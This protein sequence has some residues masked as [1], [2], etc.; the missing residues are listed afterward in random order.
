MSRTPT[1]VAK[2][3]IA[4]ARVSSAR[5][6]EEGWSLDY[7]EERLRD[8]AQRSGGEI[9]KLY[10]VTETASKHA[11]RETFREMLAFARANA[12]RLD[13]LLVMKIDRAARNMRDFVELEKLEEDNGIRLVSVTQP[14]EN[15]PAGR[16]MRRTFGVFASYF[17]DQLS[18][19]VKQAM[20]RRAEAG[21]FVTLAPYGYCNVVDGKRRVVAIDAR[22]AANVQRIFRMYAY[23]GHT[24]DS[25]AAAL[26]AAGV[27][28]TERKPG[29]WRSKLHEMLTDR[30]YIGEV[31]HLG[32][33]LP[34]IHDP[35]VDRATFDRVQM[36][37]GARVYRSHQHLYGASLIACGHC[38]KPITAE[39][40]TKRQ[41]NGN[42]HAYTY[43]RCARYNAAGHPRIRVTEAEIDAQVV[44]AFGRLRID[45]ELIREWIGDVIRAQVQGAQDTGRA[46]RER[47]AAELSRVTNRKDSLLNL[48]LGGEIDAD[49]YNH[50]HRELRD[51]EGRLSVELEAAGRGQSED[52][53][54]A[55]KVFELSQRLKEKWVGAETDARRR[56]LEILCLNFRLDGASVEFEMIKPFA[57]LSEGLVSANSAQERTRLGPVIARFL[58]SVATLP[59]HVRE[60][61]SS[62]LGKVA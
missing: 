61:I 62:G 28:Y 50:K 47:I 41:K 60:T 37:L 26:H 45:D 29:W 35:I 38:G 21:L 19:D 3:Y 6:K 12:G 13:G 39:T 36:L 18:V 20:K 58:D 27:T 59:S 56:L 22:E 11:E 7:Q 24:L 17:T 34:G 8:F 30:S 16:M 46:E 54:L 57:V 48:R 53:E 1:A 40:K 44:V 51:R 2:R 4:W 55:V 33:W 25:L 32:T 49:T 52:A 9:V 31:D 23:E 14:T 42:V 10:V 5:Q 15:T 43:Y